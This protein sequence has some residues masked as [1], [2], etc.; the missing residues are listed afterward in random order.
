MQINDINCFAL[1]RSFAGALLRR[2]F[3]DIDLLWCKLRGNEIFRRGAFSPMRRTRRWLFL[4]GWGI[5]TKTHFR[6]GITKLDWFLEGFI[7]LHLGRRG[8]SISP[9]SLPVSLFFRLVPMRLSGSCSLKC[10]CTFL[11]GRQLSLYSLHK[12]QHR[13]FQTRV[14]LPQLPVFGEQCAFPR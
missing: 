14:S 1:S 13:I 12:R 9:E 10:R 5:R 6:S 4:P 7:N 2:R 3:K 8:R 11:E